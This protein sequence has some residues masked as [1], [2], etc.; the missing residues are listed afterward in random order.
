MSDVATLKS[1]ME[2]LQECG[3]DGT[4]KFNLRNENGQTKNRVSSIPRLVKKAK[5]KSKLL[6]VMELALPF[7]PFTGEDDETYNA[8]HKFRPQASATFVALMLKQEADS[9]EALKS[10][11]MRRAGVDNW[12]TSD[13]NTLT[14]DDK[15][16]FGKYRVPS[17]YTFPVVHVDIPVMTKDFGRDYIINVKRD[18]LTNDVVGEKPL[19]IKANEFFRDIA[20]EE[21]REFKDK[22]ASGELNLTEKQQ[23]QKTQEIFGS[24]PVSDDHPINYV[25]A[26]EIPLTSKYELQG[27]YA[28]LDSSKFKALLVQTKRT[29]ALSDSLQKYLTGEWSRYDKHFDFVEIDMVCPAEEG[30]PAEIGQGTNYEKPTDTLDVTQFNGIFESVFR[31][32][33]DEHADMEEIM[34]NSVRISKYDE[35]VEGQLCSALDSVVDPDNKYLTLEVIKRHREFI[36]LALGDKGT[37]LLCSLEMDDDTRAAGQL[38]A[39][40]AAS[41][42][43]SV[44][45]EDVMALEDDENDID[46]ETIE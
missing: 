31:E 18:P 15:A 10:T 46:L 30:T 8:D 32:Y 1:F 44:S 38:D 35:T 41:V 42:A 5:K 24:V 23:K 12:D 45:L 36:T 37:E 34:I 22:C 11:L 21:Y 9:N 27:N 2:K 14:D 13:Y 43:K 26:A 20:Y 28:D 4:S 39:E 29:K 7:N 40:D 16:I 19:A 25:I 3:K 33:F 6:F 17:V